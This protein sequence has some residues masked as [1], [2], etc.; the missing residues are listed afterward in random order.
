MDFVLLS[1]APCCSSTALAASTTDWATC[2]AACAD[3]IELAVSSSE[4]DA[5]CSVEL[6]T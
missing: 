5:I 4:E 1:V 3:C 6:P 2:V